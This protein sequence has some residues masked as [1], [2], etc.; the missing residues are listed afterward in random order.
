MGF[1]GP[2]ESEIQQKRSSAPSQAGRAER[3]IRERVAG[4]L[5]TRGLDQIDMTRLENLQPNCALRGILPDGLV[6]VVNVQWYAITR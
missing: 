1:A 2:L 4:R 6:T 3:S 5:L